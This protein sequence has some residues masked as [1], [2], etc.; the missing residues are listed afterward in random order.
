MYS[1]LKKNIKLY[2]YFYKFN[3]KDMH[4]SHAADA[5]GKNTC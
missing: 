4:G 3:N 2:L 1:V 5:Q